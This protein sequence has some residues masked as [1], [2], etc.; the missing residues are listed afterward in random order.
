MNSC[1]KTPDISN[2]K[3]SHKIWQEL[4]DVRSKVLPNNDASLYTYEPS[5]NEQVEIQDQNI[6][7]HKGPFQH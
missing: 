5:S 6:P 3:L 2:A 7:M 1:E 4:M